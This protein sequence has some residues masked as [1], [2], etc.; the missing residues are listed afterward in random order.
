[1]LENVFFVHDFPKEGPSLDINEYIS[2][3]EIRIS[4]QLLQ[5][6]NFLK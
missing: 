1:M 4:H 3:L 6:V 5:I 2:D